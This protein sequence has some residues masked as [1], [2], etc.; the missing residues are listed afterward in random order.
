MGESLWWAFGRVIDTGMVSKTTI[1]RKEGKF[2]DE[3]TLLERFVAVVCMVIGLIVVASLIG[4][5]LF[6]L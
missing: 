3:R 5:S 6:N 1:L 4:N 2:A